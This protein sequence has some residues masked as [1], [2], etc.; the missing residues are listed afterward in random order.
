MASQEPISVAQ[1]SAAR[2]A[3]WH[4]AGDPI[5]TLDAARDW[6]TPFG[7]VMFAPRAQQLGAPAPSLVEATLGTANDAPPLAQTETARTLAARLVGEGH[8]VPLNLLGGPG[9]VPDFI[10]SAQ[11]FSFLYTLRGDKLWKQPPTTSGTNSVTPLALS[12][13]EML[14]E[15]GALTAAELASELGRE[16]TESAVAR[17]LQELWQ[18]MRVIPL[19]QQGEGATQWELTTRRFT[20]AIKAGTNAGQPTALSALVSL[21]LAQALMA[22][23]E[24]VATFL[25]P[26][27]PRSRIREVLH[28][29]VA[30]RELS[31]LVIE[32]KTS[33]HIPGALPAFPEIE[34][35]APEAGTAEGTEA[36][37]E[38][39]QAG[40][41]EAQGN[42]KRFAP[43]G[44]RERSSFRGKP[45]AGGVRKTFSAGASDRRSPR[46]PRREGSAPTDRERRPFS[47]KESGPARPERSQ[48][49]KPW[50]E[51]RKPRPEASEGGDTRPPRTEDRGG[52]RPYR[53][54]PFGDRSERP[55]RKPFGDRSDRPAHTERPARTERTD[56]PA[57]KP[58][59][60]GAARGAR[61]DRKPFSP[62][63]AG[64]RPSGDRPFRP[65]RPSEGGEGRPPRS[66]S[67]PPRSGTSRSGPSDRPARAPRREGA[68][69][70][71]PFRPRTDSPERPY[72]ARPAGEGGFRPPARREGAGTGGSDRPPF[73][74]REEGEGSRAEGRPSFGSRAPRS[75]PPSGDRK[76]FNRRPP[77]EDGAE[78]PRRSFSGNGEGSA[79]PRREFGG[80]SAPRA[81]RTGDGPSADERKG[82]PRAGKPFARPGGTSRPSGG[83]SR[84][85][86]GS[87]SKFES[88]PA[89]KSAGKRPVSKGPAKGA[90][91][92]SDDRRSGPPRGKRPPRRP[93]ADE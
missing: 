42:I 9:D 14:A 13:Y 55:A 37:A 60:D 82:P 16:L 38:P 62:R 46:P 29:L 56:R 43:R 4:Q 63:P 28:A 79:R 1:L 78:R 68:E 91:R 87:F 66:Y 41:E 44:D 18:H 10:A 6:L 15:R 72:R 22:T 69:G 84:P 93:K 11:V 89:G 47:R 58:F 33:L 25:S 49:A 35:P 19:L 52:E 39:A 76:P 80:Y 5:L 71:R 90:G 17:A 81:G 64:D 23:E 54:K 32:G 24:E 70:S 3:A 31:E 67:G 77:G 75:G 53:A 40:A 34:A 2:S 26:V 7:L 65:A 12:V 74:R 30:A 83:S 8:A 86:G 59:G 88:R 45:A 57:R 73:R 21:Y 85:A 36:S 27:S 61:P 51:D 48:Y 92:G 50:D 20:K